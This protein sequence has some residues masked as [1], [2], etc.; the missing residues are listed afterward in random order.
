VIWAHDAAGSHH[1]KRDTQQDPD[2]HN[3]NDLHSV[4]M[5]LLADQS[6]MTFGL[7]AQAD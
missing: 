5:N 4:V 2:N 6:E 1:G 3:R 7:I